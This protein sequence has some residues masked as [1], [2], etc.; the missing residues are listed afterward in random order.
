MDEE[1]GVEMDGTQQ[2]SMKHMILSEL[3]LEKSPTKQEAVTKMVL[4]GAGAGV[5][6]IPGSR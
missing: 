2:I 6:S 5:G 1:K 3:V 4:D